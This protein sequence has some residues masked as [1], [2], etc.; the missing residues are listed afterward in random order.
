MS[1]QSNNNNKT[2]NKQQI[3]NNNKT[4]NE[5]PIDLESSLRQEKMVDQDEEFDTC[6]TFFISIISGF[7]ILFILGLFFALPIAEIVMAE[8]FRGDMSCP[9]NIIS[10]YTWMLIE[11]IVGIFFKGL[12]GVN[13]VMYMYDK[14][15][16]ITILVMPMY[17]LAIFNFAWT[18]TGAVMFWRNC[19]D[20]ETKSMNDFYWTILIINIVI[21][22]STLVSNCCNDSNNKKK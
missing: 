16:G 3:N 19:I 11:G 7:F 4:I 10:P 21:S 17:M 2:I 20:L 5:Q 8:K 18:I 22:F 14:R 12:Y 6:T 1:T 13:F 15:D 9:N